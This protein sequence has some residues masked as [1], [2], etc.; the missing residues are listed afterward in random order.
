MTE[1][2]IAQWFH[3]HIDDDDLTDGEV[4]ELQQLVYEAVT[5]KILARPGVHSFPDH[6][7]L[8]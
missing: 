5:S 3:G 1:E 6:K 4:H 8:Q 2:R 7:T